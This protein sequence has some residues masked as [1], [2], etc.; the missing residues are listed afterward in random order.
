MA[1]PPTP[2]VTTL[3]KAMSDMALCD[4]T[5]DITD[6]Y[7]ALQPFLVPRDFHMLGLCLEL[8]PAHFCDLQI[9]MDDG[10]HGAEIYEQVRE[11]L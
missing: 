7:E 1:V 11:I 9:C 2:H 6:V 10:I 3:S 4:H 5:A 8:C